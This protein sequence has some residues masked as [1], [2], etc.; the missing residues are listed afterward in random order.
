MRLFLKMIVR[1]F[2][3]V[4]ECIDINQIAILSLLITTI[5]F[6]LLTFVIINYSITTGYE[7]NKIQYSETR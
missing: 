6:A 7:G 3:K 2:L 4:I 5:L 1:Q